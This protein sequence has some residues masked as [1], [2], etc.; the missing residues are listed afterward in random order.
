MTPILVPS[1]APLR[2]ALYALSMA[3]RLPDADLL[4][5]IIRRYPLHAEEL[6]D[7]GIDLVLDAL[8]GEGAAEAAEA[9]VD[10][11]RVS[12]VVS[13]AMSRFQNR[14]HAVR[15]A[16]A[17]AA[18]PMLPPTAEVPNPFVDLDRAAFR[19]FA[20]RIGANTA[21]VLKLRD[22]QIEPETIPEPFQRLA[23]SELHAPLDV[24]VAHF[25]AARSAA[26]S[27]RQFYKADGKPG[28]EHRQSF[29]EAVASSGLTAEQQ[30]RL[31]RL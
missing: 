7:F 31:L 14:L 21:F 1:A 22:R 6:T 27:G 20:G 15:Q 2:E 11:S 3:Q 13:R 28:S 8:R 17:V 30:Q 26:P 29:A 4:D 18:K 24:V 19:S 23:A 16:A 9:A 25:A 10:P 5:D 12:P